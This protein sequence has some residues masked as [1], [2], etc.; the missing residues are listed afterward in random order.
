M[1]GTIETRDGETQTGLVTQESDTG[2]T[3]RQANGQEIKLLRANIV[4]LRS[5]GV[6]LMPEGLEAGLSRQSMADLLQ[7]IAPR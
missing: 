6:S 1:E 2:L 3:L 5:E 7:F 4:G